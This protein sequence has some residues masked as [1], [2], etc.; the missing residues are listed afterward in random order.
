MKSA[1][2]ALLLSAS[3]AAGAVCVGADPCKACKDCSKCKL[4]DPKNPK[5]QSCGTCRDQDGAAAQR[6]IAKRAKR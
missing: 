5:A 1:L 4:C 3:L 2:L 6:R